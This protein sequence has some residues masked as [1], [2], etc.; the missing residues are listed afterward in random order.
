LWKIG[1]ATYF[2]KWRVG[3]T[4]TTPSLGIGGSGDV[5][6]DDTF[7]GQAVDDQGNPLTFIAID[8]QTMEASGP[9]S[10]V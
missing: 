3:I 10:P 7:V 8:K 2:Q 6:Y 5:T 1:L 4:V 9:T